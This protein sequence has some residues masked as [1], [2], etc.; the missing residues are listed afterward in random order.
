[1]TFLPP[2][3]KIGTVTD[4]NPGHLASLSLIA[5][6]R[7]REPG[8]PPGWPRDPRLPRM[9]VPWHAPVAAATMIGVLRIL[10]VPPAP[11]AETPPHRQNQKRNAAAPLYGRRSAG[12]MSHR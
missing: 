12:V 1:M 2:H 6:S 8:S 7:H 4:I 11:P 9:Q 3:V 10:P 5:R